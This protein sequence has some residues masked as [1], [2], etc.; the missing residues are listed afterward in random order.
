MECPFLM[1]CMIYST[2]IRSNSPIYTCIALKFWANR[3]PELNEKHP[4]KPP[5]ELDGI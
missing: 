3:V 5:G 4:W 1:V 2:N